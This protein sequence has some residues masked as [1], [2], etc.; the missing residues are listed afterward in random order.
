VN[1]ANSGFDS[2]PRNWLYIAGFSLVELVVVMIIVAVLAFVALPRTN[3]DATMLAAEAERLAAEIRYAQSLAMTR[4]Q[5]HW[6][7]FSGGNGYQ[8]FQSGAVAVPHPAGEASPVKMQTGTTFSLASLPNSLV[9]F[10]GLGTPYTDS[11]PVSSVLAT[12]ADITVL[13]GTESRVVRVYSTTGFVRVCA[14]SG[15]C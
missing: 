13:R 7:A 8:F 14:V 12:N 5:P 9:A 15:T 3:N 1:Q 6:I 2:K 4:G 10:N 11:T